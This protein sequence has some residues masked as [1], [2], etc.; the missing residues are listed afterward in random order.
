M[1]YRKA[2]G[3]RNIEVGRRYVYDRGMEPHWCVEVL[4]TDA[5]GEWVKAVF[6]G[7]DGKP[8]P[9]AEWHRAYKIVGRWEPYAEELAEKERARKMA[10]EKADEP[11]RK[12]EAGLRAAGVHELIWIKENDDYP[13]DLVLVLGKEYVDEFV[14]ALRPKETS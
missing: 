14:A 8:G 2:L 7:K 12:L 10:A 3:F 13:T 4:L 11:Q 5:D 6:I 9:S 1:G